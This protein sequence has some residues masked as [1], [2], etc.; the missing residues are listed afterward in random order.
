M[1]DDVWSTHFELPRLLKSSQNQTS[2]LNRQIG[3]LLEVRSLKVNE[4][5]SAP[6][7]LAEIQIS[8]AIQNRHQIPEFLPRLDRSPVERRSRPD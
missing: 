1:A 8:D 3:L 6:L 2:K 5:P 4:Y 7:S